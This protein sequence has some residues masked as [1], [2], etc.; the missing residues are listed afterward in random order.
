LGRHNVNP[1]EGLPEDLGLCTPSV[2]ESK[3]DS[4]I[5]GKGKGLPFPPG[6]NR[7][8]GKRKQ[9]MVYFRSFLY[10]FKLGGRERL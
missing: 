4:F 9:A 3:Q 2:E 7:L 6:E 5:I 10:L 8:R 1:G